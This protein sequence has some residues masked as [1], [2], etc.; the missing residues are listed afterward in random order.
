[1][2]WR[3]YMDTQF[4]DCLAELTRFTNS[5]DLT[6]PAGFV[7]GQQP[8]PYGG[9]DYEKVARS[10]Q[11]IEAY[12]IGGTNE[13]LRSL[14]SWPERRPYVQTWFST[15]ESKSDA[16]FLW[17]YLLHGNR[18]V[19]AWPDLE[20]SWFN[21]G[22]EGVAPFIAENA[23]T[24]REVQGEVSE[25]ILHPDTRFESDPI[26][27]YY[28][29]PSVQASWVMDVETHGKTWPKRSS[30]LDDTCQSAGKNRVSWFKLL[31]DCGF[32]YN[33]VTPEQI[34]AGE[35]VEQ[36]YRVL[37]LNRTIAMSDLEADAIREFVRRGGTV[38]A[39]HLTGL[40]D[41][42][43]VGRSEGGVLDPMFGLCRDESRG[44]LDGKHIT[45]IDGELYEESFLS[46]LKY[47]GARRYQGMVVY[48]RGTKASDAT[49]QD[50]VRRADVLLKK[51]FGAGRTVYLNLTSLAYYDQS[52]RLGP[53]GETWRDL[54]SKL[55]AESGLHPRATVSSEGK[56]VP[57]SEL[58]Y[59]RNGD[60][61]LVGL[62]KN[63]TRQGSVDA[64]GQVSGV[65]GES[66]E[67]E[68]RFRE[69]LRAVRDLRTGKEL[70]AGRIIRAQWKPWEA[71][72]YEIKLAPVTQE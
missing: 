71:L 59:W 29:H 55:L 61:L 68:I 30:S 63:P 42:R 23:E 50:R 9:Y 16:W 36:G 52:E 21:T 1:M 48:E 35:L 32:Q 57:L 51:R 72:V 56:R 65:A 54:L 20:G 69:P 24:I 58:V 70:P 49:P 62:V 41:E 3:S 43:G 15:G 13:I 14:W 46:R 64:A 27:V 38:I 31:E 19:I 26:A 6:T 7:G 25:L 4:A 45:E 10:V 40:L 28:S 18:G 33:V 67:I 34:K 60:R 66:A 37:I 2:D 11:W 22:P 17:Y 44:Y 53:L 47:R 39:D 5:L 12:D 8:A